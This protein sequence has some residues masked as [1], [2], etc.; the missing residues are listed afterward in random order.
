[1]AE[2]WLISGEVDM[3]RVD[4][5]LLGL[6]NSVPEL[7]DTSDNTLILAGKKWVQFFDNHFH[8]NHP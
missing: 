7:S 2:G 8:E 4:E 6:C 5:I 1:M 3:G